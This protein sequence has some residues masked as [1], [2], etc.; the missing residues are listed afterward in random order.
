MPAGIPRTAQAMINGWV[1]DRILH[2][3]DTGAPV[4][5]TSGTGAGK[6]GPGSTYTD[7]STGF[8]WL[9]LGT[10]ASPVWTS[11]AAFE[12][13]VISL[14]NSEVLNLRATP[15]TLVAAPG[16]GK[17]LWFHEILLMFDFTAAYT[18]GAGDDMAVRF[19]NAGTMTTVSDTIE[20]TGFLTA[21]ADTVTTGRPKVDGIVSKANGENMP[22]VLHNIGGAEFGGGNA[23]NVVRAKVRYSVVATGF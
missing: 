14:T 17:I 9:N 11:L 12:T 13:P 18:A 6:C 3:S 10:E 4:D 19:N 1:R 5:G 15:K 21:A 20:A 16:A 2:I 23:A 7:K 8:V 22:L